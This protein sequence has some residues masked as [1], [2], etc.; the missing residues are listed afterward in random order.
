[1]FTNDFKRLL[2][3]SSVFAFIGTTSGLFISYFLNIPSG[4]TIIF[5]LVIIFSAFKF[6]KYIFYAGRFKKRKVL[7]V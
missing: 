2:I 6:V 1:L 5:T 4:A 7:S 3:L